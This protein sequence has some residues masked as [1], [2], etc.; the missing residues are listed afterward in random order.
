[1]KKKCC[2]LIKINYL[3]ISTRQHQWSVKWRWEIRF[4]FIFSILMFVLISMLRVVYIKIEEVC[5][6]FITSELQG[7][8]KINF[9]LIFAKQLSQMPMQFCDM[10]IS[11]PFPTF[12]HVRIFLKLLTKKKKNAMYLIILHLVPIHPLYIHDEKK[13]KNFIS[14]ISHL[15]YHYNKYYWVDVFMC[16]E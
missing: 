14:W 11:F 1:M 12:A 5:I 6:G 7:K 13:R 8:L 2:N 3:S 10:F 15:F 16:W 4:F 9:R